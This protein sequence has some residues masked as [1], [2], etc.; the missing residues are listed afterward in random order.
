MSEPQT[1]QIPPALTGTPTPDLML[2]FSSAQ[3]IKV[4]VV[5]LGNIP[6]YKFRFYYNVIK[7]VNPCELMDVTSDLV[8]QTFPNRNWKETK[9]RLNFDTE[10]DRIKHDRDLG[11]DNLQ[12]HRRVSAVIGIGLCH[13]FSDLNVAVSEFNGMVTQYASAVASK[14]FAF[15]P[16][17]DQPDFG[18]GGNFIMIPEC[19]VEKLVFYVQRH[20]FDLAG[21]VL[22]EIE[23]WMTKGSFQEQTGFIHTSLD[24]TDNPDNINKL[25]KRKPSRLLKCKGDWSLLAGSPEDAM[26][27]YTNA[28]AECKSNAD[29]VWH[30]SSIEGYVAALLAA[31]NYEIGATTHDEIVQK[32]QDAINLY[33]AKNIAHLGIECTFKLISYF[34]KYQPA[35]KKEANDLLMDAYEQA[36]DLP[37]YNKAIITSA[38]AVMF[39]RIGF[40]RK[41]AFFI[42]EAAVLYH[43]LHKPLASHNLLTMIAKHYQLE[44]LDDQKFAISTRTRSPFGVPPTFEPPK[45]LLKEKSRKDWHY[46]QK[47]VLQN[48]VRTAKGINDHVGVARY[49]LYLLKTLSPVLSET[50]QQQYL[51][52][53]FNAMNNISSMGTSTIDVDMVGLPQLKKV[54]PL[55]PP[56]RLLPVPFSS[57]QPL[58]I[59]LYTP[60]QKKQQTQQMSWVQHELCLVKVE[61]S[62]QNSFDLEIQSISLSTSG[63]AFESHSSSV[64]IPAHTNSFEVVLSG[65]PLEAGQL[66]IEGCIIRAFNL[67]S[68]HP[69]NHLGIGI[70]WKEREYLQK[71]PPRVTQPPPSKILVVPP[72]P[73]LFVREATIN[74]TTLKL[75]EGERYTA[76]L[77]ITNVGSL[78]IDQLEFSVTPTY[79]KDLPSQSIY[80]LDEE[81]QVF[82]WNP[83]LIQK[84][85]PL[86][87]GD[88][89][90]IPVRISAKALAT[91]GDFTFNYSSDSCK[92]YIRRSNLTVPFQVKPGPEVLSFD[93]VDASADPFNQGRVDTRR[94][95]YS[96]VICEVQNPTSRPFELFYV[97][98]DNPHEKHPVISSQ[99]TA[100]PRSVK[101]LILPLQRFLLDET[102]LP[103]LREQKGQYVKPTEKITK[104]M[105]H[106]S[107]TLYW[108]K[109]ELVKRIKLTWKCVVNNTTGVLNLFP[110]MFLTWPMLTNIRSQIA[111]IEFVMGPNQVVKCLPL[112]HLKKYELN[113]PHSIGFRIQ[114]T[115]YQTKKLNIHVQPFQDVENGMASPHLGG[116]L[117][118][119]GSLRRDNVE[120]APQEAFEMNVTFS[121]LSAGVFKFLVSCEDPQSPQTACCSLPLMV[122]AE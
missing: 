96:L 6:S 3:E 24:S 51:T 5:P 36:L 121:F 22:K 16:L 79:E 28:I 104:E 62:N 34:V 48:L 19:D 108:Y 74:Q 114:N 69:I 71:N 110:R 84:K 83:A 30:A 91:G 103:A 56:S 122:K 63:V 94:E 78:S 7:T 49:S 61:L 111:N 118:W 59:W 106:T 88:S 120:I 57:N 117:A 77:E 35:K 39:Q 42:R 65:K 23:N 43:K 29:T 60:Y 100:E 116:K 37:P 27:H 85:L 26:Q 52:E 10:V 45:R 68:E 44:D 4:V 113:Q 15:E 67:V 81:T 25:K 115:G 13:Q 53:L 17:P 1:P 80:D 8:S 109:H 119:L 33:K 50:V 11:W 102:K 70:T 89:V 82:E 73:L 112:A 64:I 99:V 32:C 107:R 18:Y 9:L 41:F 92:D 72:L 101:R 98:N 12:A 40:P 66:V 38:V 31:S 54:A 14:C 87:S 20:I 93:I 105:E 47:I 97:I 95:G 21:D 55:A 75:Y 76:Q 58:S 90:S 46:I 2:E 86:K